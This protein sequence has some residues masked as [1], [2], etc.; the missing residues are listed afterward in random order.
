MSTCIGRP[1]RASA[2]LIGSTIIAFLGSCISSSEGPQFNLHRDL[3]WSSANTTILRSF[4]T[5]SLTRQAWLMLH[6]FRRPLKNALGGITVI[7][8]CPQKISSEGS[9]FR[10]HRDLLWSSGNTAILRQV[11]T[12][13]LTLK[14]WW[15]LRTLRRPL[16]NALGDITVIGACP[17][18]KPCRQ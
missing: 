11:T 14:A 4:I 16:Q 10:S 1:D 15:M 7:G 17:T 2:R 3:L 12:F 9:Q 18:V 5:L 13:S 8:P 6:S